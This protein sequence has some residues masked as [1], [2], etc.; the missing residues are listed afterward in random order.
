MVN[1]K[2]KCRHSLPSKQ[3][4]SLKTDED[5]TKCMSR[6]QSQSLWYI[7]IGNRSFEM[8]HNWIF[9]ASTDKHEDHVEIREYKIQ[10][11]LVT[12]Q[13]KSVT[14]SFTFQNRRG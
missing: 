14:I 4:V 3:K 1:N 13:F 2:E 8:F 9:R 12:A 5:K 11:M 7:I 10:E 6:L